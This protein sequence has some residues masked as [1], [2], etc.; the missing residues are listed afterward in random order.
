VA[1]T[2]HEHRQLQPKV[3]IRHRHQQLQAKIAELSQVLHHESIPELLERCIDCLICESEILDSL[4]Q[5][6]DYK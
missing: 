3:N 4:I 1:S 2:R 6:E 5:I